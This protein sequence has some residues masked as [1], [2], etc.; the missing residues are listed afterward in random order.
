MQ[1]VQFTITK[2]PVFKKYKL[3]NKFFKHIFQ[4]SHRIII[5]SI[6]FDREKYTLSYDI[7]YD[8]VS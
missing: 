4:A 6:S 2:K 3:K 7:R 8:I 1:D 5:W